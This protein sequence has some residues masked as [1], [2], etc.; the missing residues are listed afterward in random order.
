D[1]TAAAPM[2]LRVQQLD[3]ALLPL[4]GLEKPNAQQIQ[5]REALTKERDH[6][7]TTLADQA[8]RRVGERVLPLRRIQKQ[9]AADAALVLWLHV[10]DERLGCVLRR[11]GSAQW[12]RLP[13]SGTKS[14]WTNDDWL[15]PGRVLAALA[16]HR[17]EGGS[18]QDLR[19]RLHG[20]RLAPLEK[21]LR[22]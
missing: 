20:Q 10:L 18:G 14:A 5:R 22:G 1:N 8:A 12:V 17:P 15:L 13:G 19:T 6:L 16:G 7:L 21:H 11:E 9:L 4:L 2:R 3:Q